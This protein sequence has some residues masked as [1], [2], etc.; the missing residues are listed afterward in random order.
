M[1]RVAQS[2]PS[3]SDEL[4]SSQSSP[5]SGRNSPSQGTSPSRAHA[6]TT[7]AATNTPRMTTPTP[8]CP[9]CLAINSAGL[10]FLPRR[11]PMY[12]LSMGRRIAIVIALVVVA[13]AAHAQIG[14]RTGGPAPGDFVGTKAAVDLSLTGNMARGISDRDLIIMRGG[15]NFWSGPWGVFV[16]PYYLY[17]DVKLGAMPRVKTDDERYLRTLVF[18]TL[19]DPIFAYGVAALD[20]SLRRRIDRRALMGGGVGATLVNRPGLTFLTS[21]GLLYEHAEFGVNKLPDMSIV[22]A[23]D[24]NVVRTSLRLYG[25]YK[26]PHVNLI[27]DIYLIPNIRDLH[28]LRAMFSGVLEVPIT[29]GFAGRVAVDAT[30]EGVIVPGTQED[31]IAITF[32]VSYKNDWTLSEPPAPTPA[33]QQP[34]ADP[35]SH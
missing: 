18:R 19:V 3:P 8:V 35:A 25:R 1:L 34:P 7:N 28:D 22:P 30:H 17:G 11:S 27:H 13:R 33:A 15:L 23:R 14:P 32:G 12:D 9:A 4:P 20:H 29:H 5:R 6:A 10:D 16:Q 26:L 21:V 24:R 2:Q 31:D